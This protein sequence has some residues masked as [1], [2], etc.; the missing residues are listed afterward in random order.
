MKSE[1][2][3]RSSRG[4]GSIPKSREACSESTGSYPMV[5]IPRPLHHLATSRPILPTPMT[6]RVLPDNSVPVYLERSQRPAFKD[7]F[8]C[9]MLR[10]SARMWDSA[11]SPVEMVFPPGVFTTRMPLAVACLTSIL[12]TPVPAR[13]INFRFVPASMISLVTLVPDRTTR[14]SYSWMIFNSSSFLMP[15]I[16]TSSWPRSLKTFPHTGSIESLAR[17]L[18]IAGLEVA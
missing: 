9:G 10:A 16:S 5:A 11:S 17:I 6:P 8:P 3:K 13:P 18:A 14:P 12:S 7:A 1:F 15:G 2:L 4:T